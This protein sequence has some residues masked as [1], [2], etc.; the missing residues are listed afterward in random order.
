MNAPTSELFGLYIHWPFCASKCP[1]CD[2]NS[3]VSDAINHQSWADAYL[4]ELGHVASKTSERTITSIFFGG[5]TPSL[6]MPE[7]VEQ[8]LTHVRKLWSVAPNIEIT[9]EANPT[10]IEA[11]KFESFA[12]AGINR[13][14]VGIQSLSDNDLKFLGRQHN[15]EQALEALEVAT[16]NFERFSFDLIYARP[17]QTTQ[18]WRDELEEALR[19]ENGHISLYQLTIEQGTPFFTQHARGDFQVPEQ[20]SAGELYEVTQGILSGAGLPAYEVSNHARLGQE[21][22]HNLT[23]WRYGDYAGIGPGAHGR[24]TLDGEKFATRTHRAPDIWLERVNKN[25]HGYHDFELVNNEARFSECMMMGMRLVEGVPFTRI[26]N[27]SGKKWQTL[28]PDEKLKPLIENGFIKIDNQFIRPT[29]EG[30]QRLN[31]LL[32]YLL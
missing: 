6:M 1:Y 30:L 9:L 14:S 25:G 32:G 20:D 26:E 24:L 16:K 12:R 18:M 15:A 31:S 3:H 19:H 10:S 2:F 4:K 11:Q 5:G 28:L 22:Q 7:T 23:Y 21:S 27:E 8:I 29:A 13:V 17:E